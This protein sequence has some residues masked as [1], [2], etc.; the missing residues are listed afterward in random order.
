MLPSEPVSFLVFFIERANPP[1]THLKPTSNP[2]QT[3]LKPTSNPPQTHINTN[4]YENSTTHPFHLSPT[5][6]PRH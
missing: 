4:S 5:V 3:H 2:P 6:H 1:Q